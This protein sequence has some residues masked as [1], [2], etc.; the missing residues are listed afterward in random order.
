MK[1]IPDSRL[2]KIPVI[3]NGEE[4]VDLRKHCPNIEL[5]IDGS[6]EDDRF[7][8]VRT[9][10]AQKLH[11]AQVRLKPNENFIIYSA[12]RPIE[13]QIEHYKS[14]LTKVS[15]EYPKWSD[16]E[17]LKETSKRIA[18]PDIIPPHTTGSAIDLGISL[19]GKPLKMGTKYK[20]FN[21]KTQT[22][23]LE[24]TSQ[25]KK[26][27]QYLLELMSDQG[28][29]NYPTEWWHFSYGDRYWAA[30]TGAKHSIYNCI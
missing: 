29:I 13:V 17:I 6:E 20:Q 4:L 9:A 19:N 2:V 30:V 28:L 23:S 15:G 1:L 12:Y 8:L 21:K 24:I 27:R 22:D 10:V 14:M 25:E 3:D 11:L 16:K 7:Y 18:P 26:N 5:R